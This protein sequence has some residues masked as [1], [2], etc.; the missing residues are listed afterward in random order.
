MKNKIYEPY[1]PFLSHIKLY[2]CD[3][4]GHMAKYCKFP[5]TLKESSEQRG[6]WR[7]KEK[8]EG[9]KTKKHHIRVLK[10]K[11]HQEASKRN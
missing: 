4:L 10:K 7:R 3:N 11:E 2:V 6:I 8:Q 1:P 5:A 9:E